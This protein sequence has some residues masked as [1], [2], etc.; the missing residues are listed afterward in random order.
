MIKIS[1]AALVFSV[2]PITANANDNPSQIELPVTYITAPA[3][4]ADEIIISEVVKSQEITAE[5]GMNE[6]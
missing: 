2:M 5:A 3:P 4:D 1:L 6:E